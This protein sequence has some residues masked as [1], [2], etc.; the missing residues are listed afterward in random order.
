[1]RYVLL[2]MAAL[3]LLGN[4]GCFSFDRRENRRHI[5]YVKEDL[6]NMHKDIDKF[7]GLDKPCQLR[8]VEHP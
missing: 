2:A 6:R 8:D 3:M 1:M 7:L 5:K 4:A